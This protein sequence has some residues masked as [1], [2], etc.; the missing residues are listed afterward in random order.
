MFLRTGSPD[1]SPHRASL[2]K[3]TS[4][5]VQLLAFYRSPHIRC[6]RQLGFDRKIIP[7]LISKP[8]IVATIRVV[9]DRH[10]SCSHIH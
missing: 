3:P 6:G 9:N 10:V 5:V 2:Y 4:L 7:A 1:P 8:E